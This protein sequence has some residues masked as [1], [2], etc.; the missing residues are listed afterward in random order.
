MLTTGFLVGSFLFVMTGYVLCCH[1]RQEANEAFI[2]VNKE[3][4]DEMKARLI[5]QYQPPPTYIEAERKEE[6]MSSVS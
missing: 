3:A 2:T 6:N 1:K 5:I 4:Y